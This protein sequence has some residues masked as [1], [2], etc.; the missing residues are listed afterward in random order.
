[1]GAVAD[2]SLSQADL[3]LMH[4]PDPAANVVSSFF[5]IFTLKLPMAQQIQHVNGPSVVGDAVELIYDTEMLQICASDSAASLVNPLL[6]YA[7][8]RQKASFSQNLFQSC[9]NRTVAPT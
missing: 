8:K 6:G 3:T 5:D 1:M 2:L 4:K 9:S 7:Q